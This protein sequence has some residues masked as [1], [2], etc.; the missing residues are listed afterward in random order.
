MSERQMIA[1]LLK[2]IEETMDLVDKEDNDEVKELLLG[3]AHR[4]SLDLS[5]NIHS[6]FYDLEKKNKEKK[7][8]K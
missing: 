5:S 7:Y 2:D 8:G 6:I 4:R 3:K 1:S